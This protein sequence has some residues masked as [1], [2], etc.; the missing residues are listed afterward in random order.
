MCRDLLDRRAEGDENLPLIFTEEEMRINSGL[1]AAARAAAASKR[2]PP[3]RNASGN[4]GAAPPAP[5]TPEGA[6]S[7]AVE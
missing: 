1:R 2:R 4:P 7:L 6:A 5:L 3:L